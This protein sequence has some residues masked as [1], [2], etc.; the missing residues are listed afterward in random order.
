MNMQQTPVRH[1]PPDGHPGEAVRKPERAP[2]MQDTETQDLVSVLYIDDNQGDLILMREA[3]RL[4]APEFRIVTAK[5][6]KSARKLL[7]DIETGQ[8]PDADRVD[9]V[10]SDIMLAGE[11]G[12]CVLEDLQDRSK[13]NP[14]P[15]GILITSGC[16]SPDMRQELCGQ[17][18]DA[19]MAKPADLEDFPQLFATLRRFVVCYREQS[20]LEK[21]DFA[22]PACILAWP[23]GCTF[24]SAPESEGC[25]A[26]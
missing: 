17:G 4:F 11:D 26:E 13:C 16:L 10:L 1:L 15:P 24:L 7:S 2:A 9:C 21:T 12:L 18:A 5:S 3:A 22:T 14:A 8:H 19:V 20:C 6:G 23:G 25:A